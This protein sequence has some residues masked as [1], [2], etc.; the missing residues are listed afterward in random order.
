MCGIAGIIDSTLSR[1][2]GDCLLKKM[3]ESMRYRG[4]DN[5]STWV[6]MPVLLGHNRLSIIDLSDDANQ[7]MEFEDLVIVYNG[8]VYN[9]LEIRDELLKKGYRFR[10]QSDTEVILV[11]YKEWGSGCVDR[12]LGMWA[13]AIWDKTNK[14]LFCS[15]D[16]FGIKPFYYIHQGDK[17]YFGSEYKPLKLSPL[18]KNELNYAQ[19]TRGLL[20]ELVSYRDETY[21]ECL[22][23]LPER[24]NLVFKD[25]NVS[26]SQYWDL[27]PSKKFRGTFEDKKC[28][29]LELFRDSVRLH[30][31]SDVAVG[32]CLSGGLDSSAIA[33]V[34]GSDHPGVPYKTFTIY[35]KGKDQVDE[36]PWVKEV[37]RTYPN[38]DPVYGSPSDDEIAASYDHAMRS[39][40]AP[41]PRSSV[42][43]YYFLMKAAAQHGIKVMLDGQGADEY[44]AGYLSCFER[45]I[46]GYLRKLDVVQALKALRGY[47]ARRN[48]GRREMARKGLLSAVK[49]ERELCMDEF[50]SDRLS[51]GFDNDLEFQ[52]KRFGGSRLKQHLYHLMFTTFTPSLLHYEDRISMAFS[53][54]NRVPFLNH[55]LIEF[56]HSLPDE[57]L[58]F[59]GQTK[60][61][62]RASLNGR[63]PQPIADRTDK[64]GFVGKE[65]HSLLRGPLSHLLEA[66]FSFDRLS[67]LNP[68]KTKELMRKFKNG[69]NARATLVWRLVVLNDWIQKQ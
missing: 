50:L 49:G 30:M 38:M 45:L 17:F 10:T 42:I 57:D 65:I 69:D 36:R 24:C 7:P 63:L 51:V 61:I 18:F 55:R 13:F 12:F 44:L 60:Y 19:I 66:P 58:L 23:L 33:S 4:P 31:R 46:G 48:I 26:V 6:D 54:E 68:D 62:L 21:F 16:R 59:L 2:R 8:E 15:R 47:A 22:K 53:I 1:D 9:Y 25:G 28:H 35:Y 39:H 52:L 67:M 43:S 40:D 27:D 3:L 20:L 32:G 5:S 29:F 14:E 34:V 11:A 37:L 56:V 64:Q 41:M